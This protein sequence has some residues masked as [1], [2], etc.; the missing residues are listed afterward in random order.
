MEKLLMNAYTLRAWF[1]VCALLFGMRVQAQG[2]A[3]FLNTWLVAGPFDNDARN[4]GYERDW[5]GETS[6][7]PQ[8]GAASG[9][10][11]WAY[12]DDRLFSRNYDDYQ[13][14]FSDFTFKRSLPEGPKVAYAF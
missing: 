4:A 5:I 8:E 1:L 10:K 7:A 2:S 14:L 13:D 12:F 6:V 3:P 9:G 11:T